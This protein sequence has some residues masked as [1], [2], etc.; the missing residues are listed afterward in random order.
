MILFPNGTINSSNSTGSIDSV[1]Y[2]FFEPNAG[3]DSNIKFNNLISVFENQIMQV[4]KKALPSL[5]ISFKYKDIF[6]REYR[7]IAH[8]VEKREGQLTTFHVP[9]LSNGE[10]PSL[11]ASS[12]GGWVSYVDNARYFSATA[13]QKSNYGF[14]WDGNN[15]MIGSVLS[16]SAT[17]AKIG[18]DYGDLTLSNA[19]TYGVIYPIYECY[20]AGDPLSNFNAGVNVPQ[21]INQSNPGGYTRSGDIAFVSK[22]KVG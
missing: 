4:R 5:T 21:D 19:Q 15:Y 12:A 9:D 7:Q 8:F 17:T 18:W 3:A 1:T 2:N 11:I 16:V 20:L 22:Y 10:T 13:N 6:S 14:M